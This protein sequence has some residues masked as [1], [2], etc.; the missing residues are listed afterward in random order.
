MF[1]ALLGT[2]RKFKQDETKLKDRVSFFVVGIIYF[3]FGLAGGPK[4]APMDKQHG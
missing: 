3:I 4:T 1:G 2:L